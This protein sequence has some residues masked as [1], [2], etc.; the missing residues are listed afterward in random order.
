M[1]NGTKKVAAPKGAELQTEKP[2]S[3]KTKEYKTRLQKKLS[4][5]GVY[6]DRPKNYTHDQKMANARVQ[7]AFSVG[8]FKNGKYS[9]LTGSMQ[10]GQ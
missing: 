7:S 1:P 6:E 8:K 10:E 4:E 5:G 2:L 9:M 3:I